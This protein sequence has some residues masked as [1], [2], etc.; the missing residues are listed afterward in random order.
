MYRINDDAGYNENDAEDL[1]F[2]E[3]FFEED[4]T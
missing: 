3:L 1:F 4:I 2:G